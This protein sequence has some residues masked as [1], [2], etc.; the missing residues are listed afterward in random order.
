MRRIVL[1]AALAVV[2]AAALP[3]QQ[4]TRFAVV[5]LARVYAA[6][7][8]QSA[9]VRQLEADAAA[10]QAEVDRMTREIQAMQGARLDA[11]AAE[12]HAQALRLENDIRSRTEFL[13]EFHSVRTAELE[14]RRRTLAQTDEFFGQIQGEIRAIA[15]SEG[16]AMV[17]NLGNTPGILWFSPIVDITDRLIQRLTGR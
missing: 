7:F 15:E 1:A 17:L 13:R 14:Y 16:F 6:F 3:A 12:N 4:L 10:V 8:M 2:S 5:D 9:P 11:L